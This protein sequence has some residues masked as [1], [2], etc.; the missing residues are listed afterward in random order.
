MVYAKNAPTT[1][2]FNKNYS[3]NEAT[4]LRRTILLRSHWL[5]AKA[6]R[7][8]AWTLRRTMGCNFIS[9]FLLTQND[10]KIK[11]H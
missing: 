1:R 5:Q 9:F 4:S 6:E 8:E 2:T 7:Y 11:L 3:N 10:A